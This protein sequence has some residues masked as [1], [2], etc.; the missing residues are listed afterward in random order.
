M[1]KVEQVDRTDDEIIFEKGFVTGC[2]SAV[3]ILLF[4]YAVVA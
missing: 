4:V 1:K 3:I 2:A